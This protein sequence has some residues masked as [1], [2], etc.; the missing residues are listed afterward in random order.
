MKSS[1]RLKMLVRL[2]KKRPRIA[3]LVKEL[4]ISAQDRVYLEVMSKEKDCALELLASLVTLCPNLERMT[5]FHSTYGHVPDSLKK[6]LHGAAKLKEH[7][8]VV[9]EKSLSP[10][11]TIIQGTAPRGLP[12]AAQISGFVGRHAG[13]FYLE[14]LVL[15]SQDGASLGNGGLHGAIGKLPYL[16]HL[17]ITNFGC[18]DFHDATVQALPPLHSLRLES[19]PGITDRGMYSLS[20]HHILRFMSRLSLID[21][22]FVS[23]PLISRILARAPHLVKLTIVHDSIPELPFGAAFSQ[24]FLASHHLSFLHWD[25]LDPGP[26]TDLLAESIKAGGFPSLR[27]IR[28]PID[29]DGALQNLCRPMADIA[30]PS[31][32]DF[33][34][35]S[36]SLEEED[37][38]F[39]R[40][41]AL[42]KLPLARL[43]AQRRIENARRRPAARVLIEE[44]GV[45]KSWHTIR[46]YLGTLGSQIDYCLAPSIPGEDNGV[47][48]VY[49]LLAGEASLG[50]ESCVGVLGAKK[51]GHAVRR[52]DRET[53]LRALF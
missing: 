45:L 18:L 28:A 14:T 11:Q 26:A 13:W 29:V 2:L 36:L 12:S 15:Y 8:W 30:L 39:E 31:D 7:V 32:N 51:R 10:A 9:G 5:G 43:A 33:D 35:S 46:S 20:E 16:K 41:R 44:E 19:L 25:I 17:S 1:T 27:T 6:A 42:R 4:R 23:A 34:V 53:S 50:T 47:V 49:D 38:M 3:G 40:L 37:A 24:P 48:D 52:T 21:L 22:G